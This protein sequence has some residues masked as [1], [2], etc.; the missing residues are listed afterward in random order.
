M[1]HLQYFIGMMVWYVRA[2]GWYALLGLR[3]YFAAGLD[4]NFDPG[5]DDVEKTFKCPIPRSYR[6]HL[7]T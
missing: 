7:A 5:K 2:G 6:R 1:K 3:L 4:Q